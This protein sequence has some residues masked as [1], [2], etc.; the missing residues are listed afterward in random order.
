MAKLDSTST[1]CLSCIASKKLYNNTCLAACPTATYT[2]GG[3]CLNCDLTCGSCT[4]PTQLNCTS[5]SV[6]YI[7]HLNQTMCISHC[8]DTDIMDTGLLQ[9]WSCLPGQVSYTGTCTACDNSC[10]T[11]NAIMFYNCLTCPANRTLSYNICECSKGY[12]ETGYSYCEVKTTSAVTLITI[13]SIINVCLCL[14]VEPMFKHKT[15]L[16]TMVSYLQEMAYFYYVS[17]RFSG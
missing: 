15:N 8:P 17:V 7:Y 11:C 13:A 9:C 4:G 2:S 6:G 12:Q 1:S 10:A 5:C 14:I 16:L 3:I